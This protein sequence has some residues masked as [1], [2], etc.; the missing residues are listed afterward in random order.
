VGDAADGYPGIPGI[1]AKTTAQLSNRH[2]V[3]ESFP[4]VLGDRSD[5]ADGCAAL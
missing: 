5:A 1:G 2:G 4:H 3:I